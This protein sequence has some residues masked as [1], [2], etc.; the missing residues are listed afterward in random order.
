MT[1]I[2]GLD[3][4]R[5]II[6]GGS[7]AD[8]T[9]FHTGDHLRTP[10]MPG[11]LEGIRRLVR[12]RFGDRVH[13]ISKCYP[14]IEGRTREWLAHM[15]F[16]DVTGV[17]PERWHFC[18]ERNEKGPLCEALGI[19][20]F[21]DDRLENLQ[22]GAEVGVANLYWFAPDDEP[23]PEG[24]PQTTRVKSWAELVAALASS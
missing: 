19:T 16:A 10:A 24:S 21:V 3:I 17:G 6:S 7:G 14:R 15:K 1:E 12:D 13:L 11:A 23:V 9:D 2:L 4:G 18:K 5:V 22:Y 8:D 20:H